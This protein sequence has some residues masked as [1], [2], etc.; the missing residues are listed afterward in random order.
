MN[1]KANL[2]LA[3][4]SRSV[5]FCIYLRQD[6]SVL[7]FEMALCSPVSRLKADVERPGQALPLLPHREQQLRSTLPVEAVAA[8][9]YRARPAA[10]IRSER[11]HTIRSRVVEVELGSEL[12]ARRGRAG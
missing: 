7:A 4:V 11:M 1:F 8:V 5:F 10:H 12:F 6:S 2:R 9:F 3:I